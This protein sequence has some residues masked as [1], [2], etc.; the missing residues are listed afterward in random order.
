MI[1]LHYTKD[2]LV[3]EALRT[4][5]STMIML[6]ATHENGCLCFDW[7]YDLTNILPFVKEYRCFIKMPVLDWS[8]DVYPWL[9][10]WQWI[11]W[12]LPNFDNPYE[13]DWFVYI[14]SDIKGDHFW[15][16]EIQIF[17]DNNCSVLTVSEYI[18]ILPKEEV[19]I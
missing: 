5:V 16:K 12:K 6:W 2:D 1:K 14:P 7:D 19:F 8:G 4:D 11:D 9:G 18:E 15:G 3:N 13:L 10:E 17:L